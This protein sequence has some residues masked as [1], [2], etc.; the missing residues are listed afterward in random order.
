MPTKSYPLTPDQL[1]AIRTKAAASGL[2]LPAGD[3]GTFTPPGHSEITLGFAYANGAL[4]ITILHKD[5]YEPAGAIWNGLDPFLTA[6]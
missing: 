4:Q 5:W 2:T 6:V 3:A 1:A